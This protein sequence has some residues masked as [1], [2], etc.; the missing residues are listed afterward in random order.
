MHLLELE[1][2]F[3]EVLPTSHVTEERVFIPA[4]MLELTLAGFGSNFTA[5]CTSLHVQVLI[6]VRF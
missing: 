3:V 5:T 2:A 6:G 1:R 4:E